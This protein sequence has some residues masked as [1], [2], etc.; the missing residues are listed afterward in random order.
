MP[1]TA[2]SR[3]QA[4]SP[5]QKLQVD[6]HLFAHGHRERPS[7]LRSPRRSHRNPVVNRIDRQAWKPLLAHTQYWDNEELQKALY[8]R[9][10]NALWFDPSSN[11]PNMQTPWPQ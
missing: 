9:S 3:L 7:L 2:D 8:E 11:A 4:V 1:A 10:G 6:Q 5:T